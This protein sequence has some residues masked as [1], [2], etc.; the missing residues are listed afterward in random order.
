MSQY[1]APVTE[2]TIAVTIF[3]DLHVGDHFA[4]LVF[5]VPRTLVGA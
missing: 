2:R 1:G 4:A 5:L 3:E